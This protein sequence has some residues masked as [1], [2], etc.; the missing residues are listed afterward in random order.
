[1]CCPGDYPALAARYP[2]ANECVRYA[3]I[4]SYFAVRVVGWIPVS[5]AFWR[6]A[7]SL[8][9]AGAPTHGM[10]AW[11]VYSWLFFHAGLTVLQ[12][13]WGRLIAKAAY[14]M[15]IGD[16]SGRAAEAKRA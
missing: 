11:V 9:R 7:L 10:P 12:F 3:F 4:V 1:M 13:H 16:A 6:D 5:A 14:A 8:L 15:L 2:V